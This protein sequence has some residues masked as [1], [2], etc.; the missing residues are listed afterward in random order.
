MAIVNSIALG[1]ARGTLGNVVF[2]YYN[3]KQIARQK[4]DTISVPPSSAQVANRYRVGH[5]NTAYQFLDGYLSHFNVIE[6]KGLSRWQWFFRLFRPLCANHKLISSAYT[7][8]SF[9]ATSV[10]TAYEILIQDITAHI[11]FDSVS[12]VDVAMQG[13]PYDPGSTFKLVV[14][15]TKIG[16]YGI[17]FQEVDLSIIDISSGVKYVEIDNDMFNVAFAYCYNSQTGLSSNFLFSDYLR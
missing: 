8:A 12:G 5:V 9:V 2:Q 11:T 13:I 6:C 1:K 16:D 14:G 17:S 4:N 15:Y 3:R 10:G 7:F